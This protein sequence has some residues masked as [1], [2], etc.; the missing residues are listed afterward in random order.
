MSGQKKNSTIFHGHGRSVAVKRRSGRN[1]L[2]RTR[3]HTGQD[4]ALSHPCSL[5]KWGRNKYNT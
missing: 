3:R 1:H 5:V 4:F 2:R